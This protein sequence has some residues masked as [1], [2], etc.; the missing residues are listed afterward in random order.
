MSNR[1]TQAAAD[2]EP[3]VPYASLYRRVDALREEYAGADPYPH[4]VIEDFLAA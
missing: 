1:Q 3:L 4:I 2:A